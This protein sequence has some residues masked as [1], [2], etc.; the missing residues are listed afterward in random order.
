[1]RVRAILDFPPE[2]EIQSQSRRPIH[3]IMLAD[4]VPAARR[5]AFSELQS[6]VLGRFS[7]PS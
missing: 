5:A 1:M 6:Q 2:S 7:G 4:A 3:T